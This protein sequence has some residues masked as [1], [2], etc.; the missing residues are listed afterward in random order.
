MKK[1]SSLNVDQIGFIN[2]LDGEITTFTVN[3]EMASVTWFRQGDKDINGKYVIMIT[4][5]PEEEA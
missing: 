3:G 4:Y 2:A 1:I 5:F